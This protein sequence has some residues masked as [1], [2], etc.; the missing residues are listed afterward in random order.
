MKTHLTLY[1]PVILM[2]LK[3]TFLDLVMNVMP[4]TK[5][6]P[7]LTTPPKPPTPP[8]VAPEEPGTSTEKSTV[9]QENPQTATIKMD[10]MKMLD[11]KFL[12]G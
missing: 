12:K 4:P 6:N 7:W 5:N 11:M 9:S 10:N 1:T 3:I 2:R 8:H